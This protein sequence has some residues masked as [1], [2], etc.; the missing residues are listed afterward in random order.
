MKARI[1]MV[2]SSLLGRRV[3]GAAAAATFLLLAVGLGAEPALVEY[4]VP[5]GSHPHDVAPAADGRVWY[6]AQH[7]GAA[8]TTRFRL[9]TR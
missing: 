8:A 7:R 6:T 5:S 9:W 4:P 1:G 3:F 2:C